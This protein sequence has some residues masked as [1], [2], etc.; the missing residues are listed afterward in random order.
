[1]HDW[2]IG[3]GFIVLLMAPCFIAMSVRTEDAEVK[4]ED[5]EAAGTPSARCLKLL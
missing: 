4:R 3:V 1:M 2:M 5:Q